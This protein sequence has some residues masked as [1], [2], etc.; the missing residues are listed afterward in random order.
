MDAVDEQRAEVSHMAIKK[1]KETRYMKRMKKIVNKVLDQERPVGRYKKVTH[2]SLVN[3]SINQWKITDNDDYGVPLFFDT[4]QQFK[5]AEA[6]LWNSKTPKDNSWTINTGNLAPN[7]ITTVINSQTTFRLYNQSQQRCIVEMYVFRGKSPRDYDGTSLIDALVDIQ[8][9]SMKFNTNAIASNF[10]FNPHLNMHDFPEIPSTYDIQK[11]TFKMDPGELS[12]HKIKGPRNYDMDGSKKQLHS[13]T[14]AAPVWKT[15]H[16]ANNGFMVLFRK[17]NEPTFLFGTT[18]D[19][20]ETL[21]PIA[22]NQNV[23]QIVGINNRN[24][25]FVGPV[26]GVCIEIEQ[27]IKILC[28]EAIPAG[29]PTLQY[30]EARITPA[31]NRVWT[32]VDYTN[33]SDKGTTDI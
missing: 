2:V 11:L 20:S 1:D 19:T 26:G 9:N 33:P 13:S 28:P 16:Y 17:I 12:Y 23:Q 25:S 32:G 21:P 22:P 31:A 6:I 24:N 4:P 7:L 10:L 8:N 27:N 15:P 3:G 5:D 30:Y 14:T 29:I 18:F